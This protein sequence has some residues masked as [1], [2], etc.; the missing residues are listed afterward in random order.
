[1]FKLPAIMPLKTSYSLNKLL[2]KHRIYSVSGVFLYSHWPAP[3]NPPHLLRE[4]SLVDKMENVHLRRPFDPAAHELD[5]AFRLTKYSDLKGCGC[6]V[7]Q[8]VLGRLLGDIYTEPVTVNE[9]EQNYTLFLDQQEPKVQRIGKAQLSRLLC[10][11]VCHV[12]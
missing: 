11:Y 10:C 3:P 1:M 5:P 8:T 4:A 2:S 6:K 9:D 12:C 7:P